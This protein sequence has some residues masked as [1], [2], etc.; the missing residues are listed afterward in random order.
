MGMRKIALGILLC[1]SFS[2]LVQGQSS[3]RTGIA[4]N[5]YLESIYRHKYEVVEIGELFLKGKD[6]FEGVIMQSEW[7]VLEKHLLNYLRIHDDPKIWERERLLEFGYPSHLPT[8]KSFLASSH[9]VSFQSLP[10]KDIAHE[11]RSALNKTEATFKDSWKKSQGLNRHQYKSL[12]F[13]EHY[14]DILATRLSADRSKELDFRYTLYSGTE[15]MVRINGT[16]Y[17]EELTDR[18]EAMKEF[19]KRYFYFVSQTRCVKHLKDET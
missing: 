1:F 15:W 13:W 12:I 3:F 18:I 4:L 9:G 7:A 19:Q 14:L 10:E 17:A 6:I 16:K 11:V 5:K 8:I 2:Q